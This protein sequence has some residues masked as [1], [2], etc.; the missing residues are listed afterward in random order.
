MVIMRRGFGANPKG[1]R[2]RLEELRVDDS[3]ILKLI[4]NKF[5]GSVSTRFM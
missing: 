2:D 5:N 4:L 3:I 1:K